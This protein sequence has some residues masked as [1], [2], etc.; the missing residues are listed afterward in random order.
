MTAESVRKQKDM[1]GW[2]ELLVWEDGEKM[3]W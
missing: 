2:A 3:L 1:S